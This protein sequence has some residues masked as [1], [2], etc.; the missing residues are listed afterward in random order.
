MLS[1][2]EITFLYETHVDPLYRFFYYKIFAHEV[3]E[4]LTS[5]TFL[6]FVNQIKSHKEIQ[7]PKDF[8]F[9]IAR[10]VFL[11]FLHKK[12]HQVI[13]VSLEQFEEMIEDC[14]LNRT[15]QDLAKETLE[16]IAAQ[17]LSQLPDSQKRVLKLRLL[18]KMTVVE[19]AHAL[20]KSVDYVKTN[21]KRGI[22]SLRRL[23]AC[24]PQR[25]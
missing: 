7:K 22:K 5:E 18:E 23:L 12:Y 21:Q 25:T 20:K 14:G 15:D 24:S 2:K 11:K 3:A 16:D 1:E 4:D 6:I 13:Q 9:G 8:L 19:I 10:N 17:H